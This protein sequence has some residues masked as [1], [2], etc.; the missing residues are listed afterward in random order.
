MMDNPQNNPPSNQSLLGNPLEN[1]LYTLHQSTARALAPKIITLIVLGAIFFLA[2]LLNL[3]L[4]ELGSSQENIAMILSLVLV[5]LLIAL[6]I[7]LAL[8]RAHQPYLFYKNK[9]VRGSNAAYYIT[10]TNTKP[11][12]NLFDKI[13]KTHSL[14]L[15]NG[16]RLHHISDTINISEYVQQLIGYASKT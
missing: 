2:I 3:N 13:F 15:G 1:P 6:G 12:R 5:V 8:H 9:L 7:F 11:S 14:N 4:L 16:M 10:I